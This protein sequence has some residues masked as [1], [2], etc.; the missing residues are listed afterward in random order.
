M[1]CN[2]LQIMLHIVH[3]SVDIKAMAKIYCIVSLAE[4]VRESFGV[5]K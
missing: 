5:L 4:W 1:I 3:N 2:E